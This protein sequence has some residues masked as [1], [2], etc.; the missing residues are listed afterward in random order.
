MATVKAA[1]EALAAVVAVREAGAGGAG[2]SVAAA[3]GS[4]GG[5]SA[6]EVAVEVA[7]GSW[8]SCTVHPLTTHGCS[9][10]RSSRT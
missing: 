9:Y 1:G 2:D 3:G 5:G 4:A 10:R 7:M 8:E 6:A